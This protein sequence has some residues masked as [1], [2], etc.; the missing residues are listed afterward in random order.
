MISLA[1]SLSLIAQTPGNALTEKKHP[2]PADVP[3]AP[4]V[5]IHVLIVLSDHGFNITGRPAVAARSG[6]RATEAD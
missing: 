3:A 2:K 4:F 5:S 1:L 6:F